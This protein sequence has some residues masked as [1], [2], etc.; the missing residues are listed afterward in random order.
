LGELRGSL[1]EEHDRMV[2]DRLFD[3]F[4]GVHDIES[5]KEGAVRR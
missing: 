4:A 2:F 3:E 5:L 1:H